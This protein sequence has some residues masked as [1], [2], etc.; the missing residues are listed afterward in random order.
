MVDMTTADLLHSLRGVLSD[1]QL[2]LVGEV[3]EERESRLS[4]QEKVLSDRQTQIADLE[5]QLA[6]LRQLAFQKRNE[7]I[8]PMS[9]EVSRAL[10]AEEVAIVA[11]RLAEASGRTKPNTEEEKKARLRVGRQKSEEQREANR[12]RRL[13]TLPIV[14]E[15]IDVAEGEWPEGMTADDF[16]AVKSSGVV[17]RVSMVRSHLVVIEYKLAKYQHKQNPALFVQARAPQ[18]PA[19]G[20]SYDST[21]YAHVVV[22]RA[23]NCMPIHRIA[24]SLSRQGSPIAPSSLFGMFHRAA[25]LLQPI[26][27]ALLNRVRCAPYVSADET[28]QPMLKPGS[29]KTATGWM[30]VGLSDEEIVYWFAKSRSGAEAREFLGTKMENLMCDGYSAY[31]ST[32]IDGK[33]S[34]CWSHARRDFYLLGRPS[35]PRETAGSPPDASLESKPVQIPA[36]LELLGLIQRMYVEDTVAELTGITGAARVAHR[37]QHIRPITDQIFDITSEEQRRWDKKHPFAKAC[38]YL[39]NR[40]TELKRFLDDDKIPLDNNDSERALRVVALGRK[41]SLFVGPEENGKSLAII[42]TIVRTCELHGINAFDYIADVLPKLAPLVDAKPAPPNDAFLPYL[43][44]AWHDGR[45]AAGIG[46]R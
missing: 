26:H 15:Q 6:K 4:E 3:L 13:E 41:N 45:V 39:M 37:Q 9:Q 7:K 34:A 40:E 36:A 28:T 16:A 32:V 19:P 18:S 38:A 2:K 8:P 22:E 42:L 44:K 25:C 24:R 14:H 46:K 29:G 5:M 23:L 43:P 31:N 27:T 17:R 11:A 30:W 33:R 20:G 35:Q 1:E 10:N 12:T 21:V